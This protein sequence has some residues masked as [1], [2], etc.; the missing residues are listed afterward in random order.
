MTVAEFWVLDSDNNMGI[1]DDAKHL[2]HVANSSTASSNGRVFNISKTEAIF[3]SNVNG[4]L[5]N[6]TTTI[7]GITTNAIEVGRAMNFEGDIIYIPVDGVLGLAW[8]ALSKTGCKSPFFSILTQ[9][10]SPVFTI[11]IDP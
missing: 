6:D 1:T 5:V 8:P 2:Y 3:T 11:Y 7:G 10:D 9:L 4:P